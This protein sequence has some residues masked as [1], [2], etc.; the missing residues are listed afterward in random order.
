MEN[1]ALIALAESLRPAMEGLIIRRVVQHQ[2][3]GFILQ[4]RSPR[5]PALKIVMNAQNPVLYASEVKPPQ[6]YPNS[7]FLMVLRKHFTSA[8]LLE[9]RKPLSERVLEF[10]FKT[11]VPSKELER[12]SLVVELIP[13]APNIVLLDAQRRVVTSLHPLSRQHELGEFDPY[14]PPQRHGKMPLEAFVSG[15]TPPWSDEEA[16]LEGPDGLISRVAGLGPVFAQELLFRRQRRGRSLAEEITTMIKQ[17]ESPS[18]AARIYT[19][20]P[21]GHLLEQN[22]VLALSH[23]IVSPFPLQSLERT[24]SAREF[25]SIV[26]AIRFY[27]DEIETRTLLEQAKQ[28]LLR[29]LRSAAKRLTERQKRLEKEHSTFEEAAGF[30]RTAQMLSSSGKSPDQRYE[31]VTVTD[32]FQDQPREVRIELDPAV[33]LR[34]NIDRL[35]KRHQKAG[36]GKQLNARR[37]SETKNKQAAI[38]DQVRRLQAIKDWDTWLAISSRIA[39]ERE[40]LKASTTPA[41]EARETPSVR[42]FRS[43]VEEGMEILVGRNSR[44][45][46]ELTFDVASPDDF[47]MHVADYSGSHVVVRNPE[48]TRSIPEKV[49]LKAAQIAAYFSQARNSPKVEVH[50]TQRKHVSKPRRA[51]S[52]LVKLSEF[53]SIRVEP[54]NWLEE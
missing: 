22:D 3:H 15:E 25:S 11:A 31:A 32:Y 37:L 27:C 34:E 16:V 9:F 6:D 45:N 46:D 4:T 5:M 8:E 30:Q 36:R 53:K 35:F 2:P 1:L 54:K 20:K 12:M 13:N 28:P 41:K 14:A 43:I 18:N 33:T 23:A 44:E 49:L 40:D 29:E 19:E 10:V 17:V 42:R 51:K 7:D 24:H 26:E 48:K 50:Y 47:W 39:A 38:L 21:L 52:G